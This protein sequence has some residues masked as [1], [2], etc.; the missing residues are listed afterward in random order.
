MHDH[1]DSSCINILENIKVAMGSNSTILIDDI[2]LPEKVGE[3]GSSEEFATILDIAT[4][5]TLAAKE[6]TR[7]EWDTLLDAVGMYVQEVRK[8]DN[9][10]NSILIVKKK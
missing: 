1:P 3:G 9:V 5:A 10:G 2:V 8:Y 7:N 4:M 6:R